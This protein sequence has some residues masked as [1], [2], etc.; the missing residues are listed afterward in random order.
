MPKIIVAPIF[1][2]DYA[3]FYRTYILVLFKIY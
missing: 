3:H 1:I 2:V